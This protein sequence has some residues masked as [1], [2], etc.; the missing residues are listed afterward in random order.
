[1]LC[2][3]TSSL[4]I[5]LSATPCFPGCLTRGE[6]S[7]VVTLWLCENF[8]SDLTKNRS[9]NRF[10]EENVDLEFLVHNVPIGADPPY[11]LM[12]YFGSQNPTPIDYTHEHH[13][14]HLRELDVGN[15]T[16]Q[17]VLLDGQRQ[18]TSVEATLR[19]ERF[20]I[21]GGAE[22]NRKRPRADAASVR[23]EAK[24]FEL[25]I[26]ASED[27]WTAEGKKMLIGTVQDLESG[28]GGS[29]KEGADAFLRASALLFSKEE[30]DWEAAVE[31]LSRGATLGSSNCRFLELVLRGSEDRLGLFGEEEEEL[32]GLEECARAKNPL[33]QVALGYR[34]W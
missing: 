23:A 7:L 1:M 19:F 18:P 31:Q 24:S 11:A 6:E 33:C 17:V 9:Q 4:I 26:R 30:R 32:A 5:M 15:Y 25:A 20:A 29:S 2:P 21:E 12:L 34:R 13:T 14:V 8:R 27:H 28:E 3:D 22:G 10:Q 16:L